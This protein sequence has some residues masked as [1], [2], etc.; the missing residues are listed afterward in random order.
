M[1]RPP[2]V[3]HWKNA[4]GWLAVAVSLTASCALAAWGT[5]EALSEGWWALS[6]AEN[7]WM[8]A[9]FLLPATIFVF[10][11]LASIR[12]PRLGGLSHLLVGGFL[13]VELLLEGGAFLSDS[14]RPLIDIDLIVRFTP[15]VLMIMGIAYLAGRSRPRW[16]AMSLVAGLPMAVSLVCAVEP[17]WRISH[18]QDDGITAARSVP[19]NGVELVW[20]PAG[21]GWPEQGNETLEEAEK[22]VA[23]LTEDGLSLAD[24]PQ[25]LWRLPT[26]NEVVRS[27]TR[28]GRNAGGDWDTEMGQTKY[29][30]S[31]DKESPLWHVH[32][33]VSWWWTSTRDLDWPEGRR[34]FAVS[35]RGQVSKVRS[36][37]PRPYRGYRAVKR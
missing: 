19:G 24:S 7:L 28:D 31:P 17:V 9:P 22:K 1:E 16:L 36:T 35:Y 34:S 6:V 21:P 33:P 29:R 23:R 37:W 4:V 18:R 15:I 14:G 5:S 8:T 2:H 3:T 27:L 13:F 26:I 32:S 10:F 20:A 30:V 12:W 25:N 11:A